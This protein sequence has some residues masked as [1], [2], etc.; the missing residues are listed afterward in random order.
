MSD[1]P[2]F[3][4]PVAIHP[5]GSPKF[6]KARSD[7]GDNNRRF[8]LVDERT[9]T[10]IWIVATTG[11]GRDGLE[12]VTI[13][14]ARKHNLLADF[15][16][17]ICRVKKVEF[18]RL[19]AMKFLLR[20]LDED[21]STFG[22]EIYDPDD[23]KFYVRHDREEKRLRLDP[24]P[25]RQTRFMIAEDPPPP[26]VPFPFEL[27]IRILEE[28]LR[29]AQET[30]FV[31][32]E[33]TPAQRQALIER[34][35]P[36]IYFHPDERF[37]SSSV[38]FYLE[39]VYLSKDGQVDMSRHPS[40]L[41]LALIS[42]PT[43]DEDKSL[44]L[45]APADEALRAGQHPSTNP[46]CYA[47]VIEQPGYT[48]FQYWFFYPHNG[49]PKSNKTRGVHEGDWEHVSVRVGRDLNVLEILGSR[50]SGEDTWLLPGELER[51]VDDHFVLYT[52]LET[53]AIY[54]GPGRQSRKSCPAD[55]TDKSSMVWDCWKNVIEV[56]WSP[57]LPTLNHQDWIKF[58]G[59]WG[60]TVKTFYASPTNIGVKPAFK[61]G[62]VD[63]RLGL[64]P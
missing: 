39:R 48:E 41:D 60:Q 19:P 25:D 62:D 49:R 61:S 11:E 17:G 10:A 12:F 15:E 46:P 5:D 27:H 47:N 31:P 55:Y 21:S 1:N 20:P 57:T 16:K 38:E 42:G 37:M 44:R 51:A 32:L 4:V 6:L 53:H 7:D 36:R 2:A 8:E 63:S 18:E 23:K 43:Q 22:L 64:R 13:Q 30:Q 33:Q 29:K 28:L 9:T 26:P 3:N 40:A 14:S 34:F 54:G 58:T 56:K 50:H 35:A 52:A 45:F 24:E 59:R